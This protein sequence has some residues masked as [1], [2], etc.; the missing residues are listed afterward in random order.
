MVM[1]FVKWVL[2]YPGIL[3]FMC[4]FLTINSFNPSIWFNF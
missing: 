3:N 2:C 1:P 4:K